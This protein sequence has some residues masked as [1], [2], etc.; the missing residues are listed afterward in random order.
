VK[1]AISPLVDGKSWKKVRELRVVDPACGS[2]SFL[3]GAYQFLLDW[4]LQHYVSTDP[5]KHSR[6]RPPRIQEGVSG[7]WKLTL[8]EKKRI[9]KDNI[10]GVDVDQKA[11]EVCKLSLLLKMLEDESGDSINNQIEIFKTK[12]LPDLSGNIKCGNSLIENDYF[13]GLSMSAFSEDELYNINAF[14]WDAEFS[15]ILEGG[16][17]DV[18]IGNPPYDVLE[19][20][21]GKASWPH[22]ALNEYVDRKKKYTPADEYKLNL[23]RFFAVRFLQ[24]ARTGGRIGAIMPL[25]LLGDVSCRGTRKHLIGSTRDLEVDCFP[26][27]DDPNK[28][29]FEEAKLSTAVYTGTA[30]SDS[31]D[32]SMIVRVYPA[33]SF[34]DDHTE[35]EVSLEDLEVLDPKNVPV[36]LGSGEAWSVCRKVHRLNKV[37]RMD[38]VDD[39]NVRRGEI[40]QTTYKEYIRSQ[41][42]KNWLEL[43]KGA[44]VG[45]YLHR[46]TMSQGE[47]EW[48]AE[49]EFHADGNQRPISRKR[50]IATQRI[51]GVD[52]KLRLVATIIDPPYYFSDSTNSISLSDESNY[53]LEYVLALV[54]SRLYQMRFRITSTNNNVGT[55]EIKSLPFREIDFDDEKE[56]EHHDELESLVSDLMDLSVKEVNSSGQKST[57]LSRQKK[58]RRQ[59]IEQKVYDLYDLTD[60]EIRT[61][62]DKWR[63]VRPRL[64]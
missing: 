37:S 38:D 15:G 8:T 11:T 47:E 46:D 26:Q 49:D 22:D 1:E 5:G 18:V 57:I 39:L 33:D 56:S 28:R 6:G 27:K 2:G 50:R 51:T 3:I 55:N 19:K 17:F 40:N 48:F 64:T 41:N 14:D 54:N 63:S 12:I 21:R 59:E 44:E 62:E 61:V 24:L 42:Q 13:D 34:E 20:E 25:S 45:Q 9:L 29:I 30:D 16:G 10:Y 32:D 31:E 52:E 23:F 53:S 7:D 58:S 43:L 60:D 36:P 35:A 4:H